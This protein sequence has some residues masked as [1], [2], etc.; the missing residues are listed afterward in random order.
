MMSS[1][2]LIRQFHEQALAVYENGKIATGYRGTRY[3]QKVRKDGGLKAAKS[4][5]RRRSK[6]DAPTGGFLKLVDFGR[7]DMSLEALA[8]KNPWSS[9]FTADE[10][11]VARNRLTRYGY[12]DQTPAVPRD[13]EKL[14]QEPDEDLREGARITVTVNRFER[15]PKARKK[16]LAHYGPKCVICGMDFQAVYGKAAIVSVHVHHLCPGSAVGKEYVVD[17]IADLRP[18][19]PNCHAVI[20]MQKP[21]LTIDAVRRMLKSS[22]PSAK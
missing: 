20:H 12:F 4:W 16:C 5:L 1:P 10:L 21:P 2:D 18:V 17:P 7:L 6:N 11:S 22:A 14:P 8:L 3:L 19:C 9:L 13:P 15:N